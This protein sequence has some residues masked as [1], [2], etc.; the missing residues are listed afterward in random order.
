M[1]YK[2]L[3]KYADQMGVFSGNDKLN[4]P[5]DQRSERYK[6]LTVQSNFDPNAGITPE[7]IAALNAADINGAKFSGD[8]DKLSATGL[9]NW[10]N[11]DG[12]EGVGD[13]IQG[14]NDPSRKGKLTWGAWAPE[15]GGAPAPQGAGHANAMASLLGGFGMPSYDGETGKGGSLGSNYS[16]LV[17]KYLAQQLGLGQA[18]GGGR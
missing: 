12:R 17:M 18:L 13:I 14:F 3:G 8:R 5:W 6:M 10:E 2:Q 7:M 16:D 1:D 15:G 9:N 4:V 11:Y